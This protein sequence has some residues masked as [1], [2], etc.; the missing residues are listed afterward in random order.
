MKDIILVLSD[1]HGGYQMGA[2]AKTPFLNRLRETSADFTN[3]YC[4]CPLCVPSRSSFLTGRYPLELGIFDND[5]ALAANEPTL[6]HALGAAGYQTVLAG[7][8]HFKGEDQHHGFDER[9]TGDIT[10]QFWGAKRKDLGAFDGTFKASGCRR[11]FGYGESPV[12]DFD[13]AVCQE[14][15]A[16]LLKNDGQ[17]LFMV[18]GFYAPHFPYVCPEELYKKYYQQIDDTT[19]VRDVP[20]A[21]YQHLAVSEDEETVRHLRAAYSG[22]I[23]HLDHQIERIWNAC[24]ERDKKNNR[25][26]VFIYT[27]DHGDQT[28]R[29]GIYGKKTLYED[30]VRIPMVVQDGVHQNEV[31]RDA[32]SLVDLTKTILDIGG[33]DLPFCRGTNLFSKE[34]EPVRIQTILE[35]EPEP[36]FMEA[37]IMQGKK[38]LQDGTNLYLYDL[39]KDPDEKQD[40]KDTE[41]ELLES[42]KKQLTN[43]DMRV[44]A[45]VRYQMEQQKNRAVADWGRCKQPP[46]VWRYQVSAQ[47]VC[48]PSRFDT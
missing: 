8:M 43:A 36:V 19:D 12:L 31:I 11:Q 40:C 13:E 6:A 1:Q 16:R 45:V 9:L 26:C 28:G 46:E 32:V 48:P 34:R 5:S 4:N 39:E 22:M 10:T 33:A 30:S 23:E 27:S 24:Q 35:P 44:S 3:A 20:L 47:S 41:P 21:G 18:V 17:P 14:A 15:E 37:L 2:Y 29:R 7:R 42:L 25:E 38:L